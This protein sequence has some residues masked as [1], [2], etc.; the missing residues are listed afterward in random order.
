MSFSSIPKCVRQA[1]QEKVTLPRWNGKGQFT[2]GTGSPCEWVSKVAQSCP[3]LCDP[4]NCSHFLLKK[5]F[6]TQG[7][8]PGLSLSHQGSGY[9]DCSKVRKEVIWL[10]QLSY[11]TL[12]SGFGLHQFL[13]YAE[14]PNIEISF[15]CL[16]SHSHSALAFLFL[17]WLFK[18][19]FTC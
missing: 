10:Y 15:H 16:I 3:T 18:S 2:L 19:T 17:I 8:N 4:M 1:Q 6:L 7:L 13:K 14:L 11:S 5:I 9:K 12:S